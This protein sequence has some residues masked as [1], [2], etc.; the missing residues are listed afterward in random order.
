MCDS[1]TLTYKV[2]DLPN[3][4]KVTKRIILSR[5]AQIYDPL[6]LLSACTITAKIIMQILWQEK[7]GWDESV[8]Q[9]IFTQWQHFKEK[10]LRL[11][12]I[13]IPRYVKLKDSISCELHG[14]SDASN[15]AYGAAI[16][17]KSVDSDGH[18]LVRL[19][20]AKSKVAPLKVI[21]IPRLELCGALL[22]ARFFE[23]VIKS[24]DINFDK[25]FHWSDSTITLAWIR[26]QS[27]LLKTFVGNRVAEIQ[28]GKVGT[29]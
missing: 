9:I 19:L 7:Q 24:S 13:E 14:F 5:I 1:D 23:R 21:S 4:N 28:K 8:P 16:Y 6:G 15:K 18:V 27:K 29:T 25:V 12:N 20:C 3:P 2:A 22:L 11:N 26:T 10:L 17:V